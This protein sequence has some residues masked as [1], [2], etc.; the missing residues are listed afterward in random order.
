MINTVKI[1]G[2]GFSVNGK[3]SVPNDQSN[4]DY[5]EVIQWIAE[6]NTPEPEFTQAELTAQDKAKASQTALAL[7]NETVSMI[8]GN[9]PKVESDSWGKQENEARDLTKPTPLIDGLIISRGLG[10]TREEL[11]AKII[12]NAD[13]YAIYYAKALGEYQAAIKA[14]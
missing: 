8:T 13:A 2:Q 10:E 11:A 14:L 4:R 5:Q 1:Q 12:A 6:G 3:M 9:T 7:L